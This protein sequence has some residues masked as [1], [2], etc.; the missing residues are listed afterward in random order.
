MRTLWQDLRYGVRMSLK[1]PGFILMAALTLSLGI[2]A[3]TA[4]FSV[5]NMFLFRPAPV[6]KPDELAAVFVGHEGG[7]LLMHTYPQYVDLRD[8][9]SVF[10]GLT[11]RKMAAVV[12]SAEERP[13]ERSDQHSDVIRGE[14]V[15][16]NYFDVL[17]V[18]PA[19][20][21]T[22]I[23]EED[24]APNAHPV[25]VLSHGLWRRRFRSDPE[26]VGHA[27][28]LNGRPFTVIGIAPSSFKGAT[29][30]LE[31]DF[32]A[33][34]MMQEQL[35][36]S[37]E[38][39]KGRGSGNDLSLLG[40]LKPG[41]TMRQ[42]QANLE[43]LAQGL[44]RPHPMS[45]ESIK[46]IVVSEIEG[47]YYGYFGW[48][49]L[50][51]ALALGFSGLVALVACANVANLLLA[52]ASAR[53]REIVIRLALGASR[54]RIIRQLLMESMPLALL[55]G[56]LGLL[57]SLWGADLMKAGWFL[58]I[59]SELGVVDFSPDLRT[60]NW[61]L[62]VSLITW[63][64]F[65]SAPAWHAAR[66]DLIPV[67]K[68]ETGA[69]AVGSRRSTLRN[70]L[71]IAQLSISVVVLVCAG[72]F[73]KTL[74]KAQTADPGF[75][76]ENLISMRLDPGLVG[77]D[78]ARSKVFFTDLVRQVETLPGVRT[79]SLAFALP[80]SAED[81]MSASEVVKEGDSPT[82]HSR[83]L[84]IER[85][86]EDFVEINSVGPKYFETMGAP[87]AAGRDFTE[88]DSAGAPAVVIIGQALA[89]RLY[90]S[91]RQALGKRLRADEPAWMEIV[92]VAQDGSI[93]GLL[94]TPRPYL[95]T[96][97]LQGKNPTRMT[98]VIRATSAS[99]FNS[100]AES[101]RR[102]ARKLDALAP[103]FQLKLGE[104]HVRPALRGPRFVAGVS[105]TLAVIALALA[106]LGLYGVIAYAVSLRTKEIGIRMALG[107]RSTDVLG[108]IIRQGMVL[109]LIGV[110][111]GLAAA[112]AL[113]RVVMNM[114]YGVSATDPLSFIVIAPPLIAVALLACYLPARRATKVDPMIALR[115]E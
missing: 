97:F 110:T 36:G 99:E 65:G 107:A 61:T 105:V 85:G 59:D 6:E 114:F 68:N 56:G 102:E 78:A 80:F 17:G 100:I 41:V 90:G 26:L 40:R 30:A 35:G 58:S 9:N 109:T 106:G 23:P 88:R 53:S 10:S 34:I 60:L 95:L 96:P 70:L 108:M 32:W 3:N 45:N 74:Y 104:G 64:L 111:L 24:R 75:Q 19:L 87:L 5:V 11:A 8:Q 49:K 67:L 62:A 1:N 47:R 29:F 2:G 21:R 63:L 66:T 113:V 28:Y 112:F 4:I 57:L 52:R 16:G 31:M 83:E 72:L 22:F 48:Y 25:V 14:V 101:V 98:L 76:A 82:P 39:F 12:I 44:A 86:M 46:Y 18:R 42:A 20:G 115:F 51:A 92:G 7:M 71:V 91:E 79:A 77:Y 73:V 69:S 50:I 93:A 15:N 55:G 37:A 81:G 13:G 33:P 38:W 43:I 27:V 84:D 89:R 94:G 103:V 54:R